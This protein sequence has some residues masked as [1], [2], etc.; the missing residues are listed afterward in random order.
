ME[1][2]NELRQ[3]IVRLLLKEPMSYTKLAKA[4]G[5]SLHTVINFMEEK[6]EATIMTLNMIE[7]YLIERGI[8]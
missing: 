2:H 8:E 3:R 1:K 6:R 7:K 4:I 5:I